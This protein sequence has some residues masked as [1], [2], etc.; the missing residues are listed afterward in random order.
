ME[1]IMAIRI[2]CSYPIAFTPVKI[3]DD[4][5]SDGGI[6][7]PLPGDLIKKKDKKRTLCILNHRSLTNNTDTLHSYIISLISCII[8]SLTDN[9]ISTFK[10]KIQLQYPLHAINLKITPEEKIQM[11]EYGKEKAKEWWKKNI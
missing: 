9:N 7:A 10:H 4:L 1:I 11:F 3:G 8:D 2:S 5:Y 6:M